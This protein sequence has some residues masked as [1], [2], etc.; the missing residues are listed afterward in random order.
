MGNGS[1]K[2]RKYLRNGDEDAARTLL[3]SNQDLRKSLDPNIS[4]GE[5]HGHNTALHYAS[6]HCM[7][8]MLQVFLSIYSGNPNKRNDLNETSLHCLAKGTWVCI[9][10]ILV[11]MFFK[12]I[13]FEEYQYAI[14]YCLFTYTIKPLNQ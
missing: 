12:T 3:N 1:S 6:K 14:L 5:H 9:Y 4:Y 11:R 8:Y 2:F 13:T 10:K 7:K